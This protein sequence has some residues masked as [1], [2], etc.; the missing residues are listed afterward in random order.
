MILV[1]SAIFGSVLTLLGFL[2]IGSPR[3][4]RRGRFAL[5]VGSAGI[6]TGKVMT[7]PWVSACHPPL[8][9]LGLLF[10]DM[11]FYAITSPWRFGELRLLLVLPCG[12]IDIEDAS[13]KMVPR[14]ACVARSNPVDHTSPGGVV[15]PNTFVRTWPCQRTGCRKDFSATPF[16]EELADSLR[17][18]FLQQNIVWV[19]TDGSS[20]QDIGAA[21]IVGANF[22]HAAGDASEDQSAFH[23]RYELMAVLWLLR[24]AWLLAPDLSGCLQVLCD[25]QAVHAVLAAPHRAELTAAA[26]EA[27]CLLR[28]LRRR[29]LQVQLHWV[30]SHDSHLQWHPPE[31]ALN[32]KADVAANGCRSGRSRGAARVRWH[33]DLAVAVEWEKNV[34]LATARASRMLEAHIQAARGAVQ[35]EF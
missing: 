19:A 20:K 23:C 5:A 4:F 9:V 11:V 8:I 7:S 24:A 13:L 28:Q 15:P 29:G 34:I 25:C 14:L 6:I 22:A 33:E 31:G 32:A 18:A 12:I 2:S 21:A 17:G 1:K 27:A 10:V 3:N 16:C 30:P 35:A 26:E